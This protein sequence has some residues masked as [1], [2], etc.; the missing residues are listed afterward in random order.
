MFNETYEEYIRSILGYN[1]NSYH[2]ENLYNIPYNQ[3]VSNFNTQYSNVNNELEECYPEI[4]KLVYPM[5]KKVCNNS[6]GNVNR[7]MV[8][9]M[10]DE[11]FF[12][13]EDDDE[14]EINVNIQLET[15]C[16]RK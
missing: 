4:Y 9:N 13:I 5:V 7:Q 15:R 2:N 1:T 6:I 14:K 8:E 11:I 12:A 10:T 16:K 3:Q